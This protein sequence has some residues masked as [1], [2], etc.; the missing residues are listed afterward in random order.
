MPPSDKLRL[1]L[2]D[3]CLNNLSDYS[4]QAG[5]LKTY[6]IRIGG[7]VVTFA[8][9]IPE[10]AAQAATAIV[11]LVGS[12]FVQLGNLAYKLKTGKPLACA[13]NW[14]PLAAGNHLLQAL[15][16]LWS[17]LVIPCTTLIRGPKYTL[18]HYFRQTSSTST[19]TLAKNPQQTQ[20]HSTV[21]TQ[22]PPSNQL[23]KPATPP[24]FPSEL[25]NK[26]LP[27]L[28]ANSSKYRAT[29]KKQQTTNT[30]SAPNQSNFLEELKCK[31]ENLNK[32]S[33]SI[34]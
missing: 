22:S 33:N 12:I 14:T 28:I 26:P 10:T 9:I 31:L 24:P 16:G 2:T 11:K 32:T 7:A 8:S 27:N 19:D 34:N 29:T 30:P 23:P 15:K 6:A 4:H 20:D 21:D 1:R 18:S 25:A 3:D 17:M 13:N 5:I